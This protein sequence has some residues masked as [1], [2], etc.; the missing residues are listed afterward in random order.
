MQI[1]K[2]LLRI[3][4]RIRITWRPSQCASVSKVASTNAA[5]C[6]LQSTWTSTALLAALQLCPGSRLIFLR[7]NE[8]AHAQWVCADGWVGV[9]IGVAV[10]VWLGVCVGTCY[11]H[12]SSC[13]CCCCS[14][15]MP[16]ARVANVIPPYYVYATYCRAALINAATQLRRRPQLRLRY[17]YGF[18][19]CL[20]IKK[21][22][23]TKGVANAAAFLQ[24]HQPNCRYFVALTWPCPTIS[25][26]PRVLLKIHI[27]MQVYVCVLHLTLL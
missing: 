6:N 15:C 17:G 12:S 2:L 25:K 13:F 24:L 22:P 7:P 21:I 26:A 27:H 8:R 10:C 5:N 11:A 16:N 1:F 14:L 4:I 18:V 3:R 9:C 19:C 20:R 23:T